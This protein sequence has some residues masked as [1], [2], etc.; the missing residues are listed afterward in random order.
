MSDS[1]STR[2][3]SYRDVD[4]P[5]AWDDW[6][7]DAK[8]NYLST[9]MDRD[10]LLET[11]GELAGIPDGEIGEQSLWKSALAQLVVVLERDRQ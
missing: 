1:T 9:A 11:V 10:Q 4:I 6:P 3:Q 2:P 5:D 7:D 8:V